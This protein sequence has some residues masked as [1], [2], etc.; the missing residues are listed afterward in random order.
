M[1]LRSNLVNMLMCLSRSYLPSLSASEHFFVSSDKSTQ[2]RYVPSV[3]AFFLSAATNTYALAIKLG[4]HVGVPVAIIPTKFD[5]DRGCIR[6]CRQK[7]CHLS[8]H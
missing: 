4:E 1:R 7:K 8:R 6:R 5:C 3:E 2:H